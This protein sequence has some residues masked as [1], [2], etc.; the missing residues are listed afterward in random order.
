MRKYVLIVMSL[1][2]VL[3]IFSFAGAVYAAEF[4]AESQGTVSGPGLA[5]YDSTTDGSASSVVDIGIVHGSNGTAEGHAQTES[6]STFSDQAVAAAFG[7]I[8]GNSSGTT[9]SVASA[10]A[11]HSSD[12]YGASISLIVGD[13]S[14]NTSATSDA[15]ATSNSSASAI[16]E[17]LIGAPVQN[18]FIPISPQT[19]ELPPTLGHSQGIANANAVADA[20]NYSE[21]LSVALANIDWYSSGTVIADSDATASDD[22][23]T[24]SIAIAVIYDSSTGIAI[25]ISTADAMNNS[26]AISQAQAMLED[27]SAG[28]ANSVASA[29]SSQ[30]SNSEANAIIIISNGSGNYSAYA[31][32]IADDDSFAESTSAITTGVL[33]IDEDE[34]LEPRSEFSLIS[35]I[36]SF[37]LD[38]KN[39]GLAIAIVYCPL[40]D[41]ITTFSY[42]NVSGGLDAEA[43]AT[44]A[45]GVVD[46]YAF[47]GQS[48]TAILRY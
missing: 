1:L 26:G 29:I 22:S 12:A 25:A 48:E 35:P 34:S 46:V 21:S 33:F 31:Y 37:A 39:G 20:D 44:V 10:T 16:A 47:V 27:G 6:D 43:N 30:D 38:A 8:E 3:G 4:Y 17:A 19:T 32:A 28:N 24:Q 41:D 45:G 14:G 11:N 5:Y 40:P 42:T 18:P 15:R 13:S 7:S 9:D 23:G 36:I 2:A